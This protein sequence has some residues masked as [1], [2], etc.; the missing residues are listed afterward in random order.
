[1]RCLLRLPP[2]CGQL[3]V[4]AENAWRQAAPPATEFSWTPLAE[5]TPMGALGLTIAAPGEIPRLLR[6]LLEH[7]DHYRRCAREHA[8]ECARQHSGQQ[9]LAGLDALGSSDVAA[10]APARSIAR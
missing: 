7:A 10:D 1:M 5:A 3:R 4:V 2:G 9:V 8:P 6:D